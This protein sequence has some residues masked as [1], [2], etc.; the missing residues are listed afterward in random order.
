MKCEQGW[1]WV[2]SWQ[3]GADGM[4]QSLFQGQAEVGLICLEDAT[5][6]CSKVV[7]VASFHRRSPGSITQKSQMRV[8]K[9]TPIWRY[10]TVSQEAK[11][12]NFDIVN[13]L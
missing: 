1:E 6:I 9:Q 7:V 13:P 2:S 5:I 11:L 4:K 10:A 8:A 12:I 3:V